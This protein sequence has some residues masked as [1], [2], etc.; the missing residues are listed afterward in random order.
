MRTRGLAITCAALLACAAAAGGEEK[1]PMLHLSGRVGE[2]VELAGKKSRIIWQ[3]MIGQVEGKQAEYFDPADG[4]NQIVV[5]VEGGLASEDPVVLWGKVL[6]VRGESKRPKRKGD[7]GTKVDDSYVEYALDVERVVW[8]PRAEELP[9][10]VERLVD[11]QLT[12]EARRALEERLVA[13]GLAAVPLLLERRL[14]QLLYRIVEPR[15]YRSPHAQE[16]RPR[17]A[18]QDGGM[19]RVKD[20][21][22]FFA[23]RP[24]QDLDAIRAGLEPAVDRWFQSKG[25]EQVID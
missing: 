7:K 9:G 18:A 21:K 3:H 17:S 10:L 5:H 13:A 20:W 12:P 1:R 25:Q 16:F 2:R 19:F 6:E 8:V 15:N 22:A 23:A 11:P 24:G 4:G 14:D